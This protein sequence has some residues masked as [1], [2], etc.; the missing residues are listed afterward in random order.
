[1][2]L[3]CARA[4]IH[5]VYVCVCEGITLQSR[6]KGRD[7]GGAYGYT[8]KKQ[9]ILATDCSG[10]G[11]MRRGSVASKTDAVFFFYLEKENEEEAV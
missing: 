9:L 7:S 5:S 11:R 2:V 10:G 4:C 1:M 6:R 3:T 8:A